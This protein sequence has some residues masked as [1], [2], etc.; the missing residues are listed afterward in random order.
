MLRLLQCVTLVAS[1][2]MSDDDLEFTDR[3][4][5][6]RSFLRV[7][8]VRRRFAPGIFGKFAQVS[9]PDEK[10]IRKD[11]RLTVIWFCISFC[12]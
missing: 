7:E 8:E 1:S 10:R 2:T 4:S 6:W 3:A 11:V 9:S 12:I 5:L